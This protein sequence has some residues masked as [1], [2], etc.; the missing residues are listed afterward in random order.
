MVQLG[1]FV[2]TLTL[3]TAMTVAIGYCVQTI[4]P[5]EADMTIA[6]SVF[7]H[8]LRLS[9]PQSILVWQQDDFIE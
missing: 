5:L 3:G 9:P 4:I 6:L 7:W 2:V 8:G 1:G